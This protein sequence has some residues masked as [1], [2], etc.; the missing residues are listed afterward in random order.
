MTS[1][2]EPGRLCSICIDCMINVHYACLTRVLSFLSPDSWRRVD[3]YSGAQRVP[4]RPRQEPDSQCAK[5]SV[6]DSESARMCTDPAECARIRN[7]PPS[8]TR[9]GRPPIHAQRLIVPS[10]PRTRHLRA[11]PFATALGRS[12]GERGGRG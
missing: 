5:G 9:P 4:G 8:P 3:H 6:A 7:K 10:R 2:A 11:C 12:G 1:N